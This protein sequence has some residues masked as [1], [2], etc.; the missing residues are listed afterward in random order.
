[1]RVDGAGGCVLLPDVCLTVSADDV[2][3]AGWLL[4]SLLSSLSSL[5]FKLS[6]EVIVVF[7]SY[8]YY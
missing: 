6:G 1:V 4:L 8:H 2:V 7:Q 5:F 3:V